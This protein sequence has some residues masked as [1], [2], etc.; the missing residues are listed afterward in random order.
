[1][2]L[3]SQWQFHNFQFIG[4]YH[5]TIPYTLWLAVENFFILSGLLASYHI[6]TLL[7]KYKIMITRKRKKGK[8]MKIIFS[9]HFFFRN[10]KLNIISIYLHRYLRLTPL[11]GA[12]FLFTMSLL[13]FLGNGPVWPITLEFLSGGCDRYWWSSLLYT[14]NYVNPESIVG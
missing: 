13:R 12:S 3:F 7:K 1:M 11:L 10:G 5:S 6:F 9:I 8:K 2:R 14:Q 4:A